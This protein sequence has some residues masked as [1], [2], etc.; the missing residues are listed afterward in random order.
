LRGIVSKF[1]PIML[2]IY[3]EALASEMLGIAADDINR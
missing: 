1:L 2:P 3:Q